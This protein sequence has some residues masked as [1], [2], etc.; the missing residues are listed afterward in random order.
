MNQHLTVTDVKM[1][2]E[3]ISATVSMPT[4]EGSTSTFTLNVEGPVLTK[5]ICAILKWV[6]GKI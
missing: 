4:P 5:I 3:T 1:E 6:C 2:E